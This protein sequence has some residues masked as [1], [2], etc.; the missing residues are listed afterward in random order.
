[1]LE[2]V[3]S[4]LTP[5]A[6]VFMDLD[7]FKEVNDQFGHAVGDITLQAVAN[8]IRTSI[9]PRDIAARL[10]GDEFVLL[11]QKCCPTGRG[12]RSR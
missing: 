9:R 4:S 1:M 7:G 8:R 10:G 11:I 2:V 5:A 3:N 6:L 12:G